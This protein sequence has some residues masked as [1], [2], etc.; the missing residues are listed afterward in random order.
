MDELRV[1]V[2]ATGFDDKPEAELATRKVETVVSAQP[3]QTQPTISQEDT[4]STAKDIV[5]SEKSLEDDDYL[6]DVISILRKNSG[7]F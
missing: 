7:S 1:T 6:K 4:T 5:N 2:V 3:V